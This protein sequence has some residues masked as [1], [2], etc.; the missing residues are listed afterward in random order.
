MQVT[1]FLSQGNQLPIVIVDEATQCTEPQCIISL[2]V[3]PSLLILVGDSHQLA[4]T[5]QNPYVDRMGYGKSLFERFEENHYPKLSLRIQYRM[6][7]AICEWPNRYVYEGQLM[8]SK[9][10]T[11]PNFRFLFNS[12]TIPSYAFINL[13]SVKCNSWNASVEYV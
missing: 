10:V 13:E 5:V 1:T 11:N 9:L 3:K 4:A 7:P 2:T 6:T 12:S 8:N